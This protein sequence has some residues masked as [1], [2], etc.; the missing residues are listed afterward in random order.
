[1]TRIIPGVIRTRWRVLADVIRQHSNQ[2][3]LIQW[4]PAMPFHGTAV[5]E[6]SAISRI[7]GLAQKVLQTIYRQV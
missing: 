2:L 7:A 1:M 4:A 5:L 3:G 6:R